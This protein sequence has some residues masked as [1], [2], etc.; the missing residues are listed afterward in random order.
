MENEVLAYIYTLNLVDII[1]AIAIIVLIVLVH[2][3]FRSTMKKE[4]KETKYYV[5]K[6]RAQLMAEITLG[7]KII[8]NLK[9]L[10]F[11]NKLDNAY[12]GKCI[13]RLEKIV[14]CYDSHHGIEILGKIHKS[15][16]NKDMLKIS[17]SLLELEFRKV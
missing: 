1:V 15:R 8:S 5:A 10:I 16:D 14:L 17:L 7:L 11:L 9:T 12:L 2:T 6:N 13:K 3:L 4:K